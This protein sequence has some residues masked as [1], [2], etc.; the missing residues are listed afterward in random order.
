LRKIVEINKK[1]AALPMQKRYL[2]IRVFTIS[3]VIAF[4]SIMLSRSMTMARDITFTQAG[5]DI[6]KKVITA[7][8]TQNHTTGLHGLVAIS[9]PRN[10]KVIRLS[11]TPTPGVK[12]NNLD[13]TANRQDNLHARSVRQIPKTGF[14]RRFGYAIL[15]LLGI[16]ALGA[17]F[18]RWKTFI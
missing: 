3:L 17:L 14:L 1:G 12:P 2:F 6:N 7:K 15:F 13:K 16:I 8:G 18:R 10:V 11:A 9:D 5:V 4:L